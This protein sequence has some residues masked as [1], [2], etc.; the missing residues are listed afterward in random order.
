MENLTSHLADLQANYRKVFLEFA[1]SLLAQIVEL[2]PKSLNGE[3][4]DKYL[5]GSEGKTWQLSVLELIN[6]ELSK[7][8][9]EL[10]PVKSLRKNSHCVG[11]GVCC[12]FAVSEFSPA[13]LNQKAS[14]GDNFASQF[15]KTFI[16][17]ED[18][19]EV[20]KVFP[21]YVEFLQNSETDGKYYFYHCPKVT[22]DNKCPDYENRPQICRDFPDNPIGFLPL[23]CGYMDWKQKSELKM[24][25]L[26][27]KSEILNFYKAKLLEIV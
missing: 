21:Q 16:P 19:D 1:N 10:L 22:S 8:P 25:E 7:I 24:L 15:V 12:K 6:R 14:Q 18:L 2:R 11:C 23:T 4:F 3:I 9:N 20:K 26:N 17:Y 13:Q 5:Q 27:A